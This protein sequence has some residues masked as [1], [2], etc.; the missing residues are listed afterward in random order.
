[1]QE[2]LLARNKMSL[3]FKTLED[4]STAITG[5]TFPHRE[6]IKSLGGVWDANLK[7]WILRP[8]ADIESLRNLNQRVS[9]PPN[10]NH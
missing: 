4:G 3:N 6:E 10:G 5:H 7:G 9:K 8:D 1:M 2:K